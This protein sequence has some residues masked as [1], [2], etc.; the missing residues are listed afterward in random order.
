MWLIPAAMVLPV[1]LFFQ[2]EN[3]EWDSIVALSQSYPA[4]SELR[5]EYGTD[6][7]FDFKHDHGGET[8]HV[9]TTYNRY[10]IQDVSLLA[11]VIAPRELAICIVLGILDTYAGD[12]DPIT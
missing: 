11:F 7:L 1:L 2:Y 12:S 9:L 3:G 10:K 8:V 5:V 6:N 4:Q